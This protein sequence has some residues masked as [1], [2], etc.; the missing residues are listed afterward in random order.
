VTAVSK[1]SHRGSL[2]DADRSL[3][4]AMRTRGH[5]PGLESLLGRYSRLGEHAACW[6]G[7]GLI[8]AAVDREPAR[9]S[10]WLRGCGV[11][12]G[13]YGL[14]FAVKLAVRRRRPDLPGLPP[15]TPTVSRLSFPSAHATTSFAAAA[16]YRGLLP[17][18]LL[19]GAALVFGISRPYLGV[20]YPSDVLAGAL[21]GTAL[22]EVAQR[23][24]PEGA[25]C[26]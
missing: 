24:D 3:L 8:G 26:R 16:A 19:Y 25:S 10:R 18:G 1:L 5:S 11:V 20:H 2:R 6:I 12:V 9:R 21:L 4:V 13:A 23:L 22:A 15:L 14:N 7:L 17:A